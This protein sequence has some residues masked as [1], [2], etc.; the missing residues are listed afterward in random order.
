MPMRHIV[1]ALL[2][3]CFPCLLIARGQE[4]PRNI[5]PWDYWNSDVAKLWGANIY[6]E[7]DPRDGRKWQ[8]LLRRHD[9]QDLQLAGAN[10]V[11]LSV[12]GPFEPES[13]NLNV[14][15]WNNLKDRIQ[16]AKDAGLKIVISFRTAPGRNEADI[17]KP[18]TSD[19]KRDLLDDP[20]SANVAKFCD[21]WKMVA[22]QYAKD[23]AVVGFDL[24]VEPHAP[25]AWEENQYHDYKFRKSNNWR[26]VAGQAI[27]AIRSEN[28]RTPILVEP[29]LWAAA[30]YLN[31]VDDA[32]PE[33]G[34]LAWKMP[35]GDH[36]VCAVHQFNPSNYTEQGTE[37]FDVEFV[38]LRHAFG[39][40]SSWRMNSKAPVCVNEFGLKQA[41]PH[42]E[43]FLKKELRLLKEQKLNHAVWLWEVTD[44]RQDYRDFDVRS[45]LKLLRELM[46][47][48]QKN[49][50]N[51]NDRRVPAAKKAKRWN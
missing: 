38:E 28:T 14:D 12:P 17:T 5:D 4:G 41:L 21:M 22:K 43:L 42:A 33:G 20:K 13:G 11:N 31:G 9:F 18:F 48:W 7:I 8:P 37:N 39:E 46:A 51:L 49:T 47:N 35:D 6:Q 25:K 36:L 45:N 2:G 44:P 32:D 19:V 10:Y 1:L 3:L 15:N 24:L 16:W 30:L 26:R 34:Q 23:D 29:D 40:I 50:E 27:E